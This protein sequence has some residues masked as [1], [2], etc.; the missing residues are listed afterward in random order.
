MGDY[1]DWPQGH[2]TWCGGCADE[3]ITGLRICPDCGEELCEDC[4]LD[5]YHADQIIETRQSATDSH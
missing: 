1:W 4:A 5:H 3:P 2:L